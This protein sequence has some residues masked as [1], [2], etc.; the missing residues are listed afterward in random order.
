MNIDQYGKR[1]GKILVLVA[2]LS[3]LGCDRDA[4]TR[5]H[6]DATM[7]E[8]LQNQ[9]L[10]KTAAEVIDYFGINRENVQMRDEPPGKL[11]AFL[12]RLAS[13]PKGQVI[14]VELVYEDALYSADDNWKWEVIR[15]ATVANITVQHFE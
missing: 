9:F 15:K 10:G 1:S 6:D 13:L 12:F 11:R 2:S 8:T 14:F 3:T 5:P 7:V 4:P